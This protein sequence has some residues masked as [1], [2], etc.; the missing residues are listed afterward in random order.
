MIIL[1]V[2]LAK[3]FDISALSQAVFDKLPKCRHLNDIHLVGTSETMLEHLGGEII[4]QGRKLNCHILDDHKVQTYLQVYNGASSP[5][6]QTSSSDHQRT[7]PGIT[8]R[9]QPHTSVN[10]VRPCMFLKYASFKI[11]TVTC[12]VV[13]VLYLW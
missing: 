3:R 12:M 1:S 4:L 9:H 8:S 7:Q 6:P 11:T 10:Q 13:C 5:S 2:D